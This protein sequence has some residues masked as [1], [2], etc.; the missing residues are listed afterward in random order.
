MYSTLLDALPQ[1]LTFAN[2]AAIVIGVL[3]GI[4]VGALPGLS[5]TMAISVLIPFTFAFEPLI[6]LGLMAGHLQRRYVWRRHSGRFAAYSGHARRRRDQ[7]R[8]LS[9]GPTGAAAGTPCRWQLS[10][11]RSVVSPRRCR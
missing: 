9:D 7:L 3:S 4:I 6:A 11:R 1:V 8:R 2:F 10:R 5:A